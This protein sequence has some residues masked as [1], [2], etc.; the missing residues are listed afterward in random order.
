L[1]PVF[2][3]K[4]NFFFNES[5]IFV[6]E[7][8]DSHIA[9]ALDAGNWLAASVGAMMNSYS[10]FH[11]YQN[12]WILPVVL[13][14]LLIFSLLRIFNI[15][16]AAAGLIQY[17]LLMQCVRPLTEVLSGG[18]SVLVKIIFFT[19]LVDIWFVIKGKSYQKVSI[20]L[21]L[22]IPFQHMLTYVASSYY[23]T[24][25]SWH[26]GLAAYYAIS[27]ELYN[28]LDV[29][30]ALKILYQLGILKIGTWG[31]L[32]WERYFFIAF[33]ALCIEVFRRFEIHKKLQQERPSGHFFLLLIGIFHFI[34][35]GVMVDWVNVFN[36]SLWQYFLVGAALL[37]TSWLALF[38]EGAAGLWLRRTLFNKW[39]WLIFG[40]LF[41]L[42]TLVVMD[43]NIF[44]AVMLIFF[45]SWDFWGARFG[46]LKTGTIYWHR[47]IQ[48]LHQTIKSLF[49]PREKNILGE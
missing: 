42:M 22:L 4:I 1:I 46:M 49:P 44:A 3:I 30:A 6:P 37:A 23:K 28:K 12:E 25:D 11:L 14:G 35:L 32:Y 40:I 31:V 39:P 43:I 9:S 36:V 47:F 10:I 21:A 41:H 34:F 2:W 27:L 29:S 19:F 17:L 18:T 26:S 48:F 20:W 33:I 5:K 7:I 13:L 16:S 24:G 38:H 8:R 45:I 15:W